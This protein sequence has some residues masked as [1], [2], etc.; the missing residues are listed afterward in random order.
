MDP[1]PSQC[2]FFAA[3]HVDHFDGRGGATGGEESEGDRARIYDSTM[4]ACK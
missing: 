3:G 1:G 2:K 4:L